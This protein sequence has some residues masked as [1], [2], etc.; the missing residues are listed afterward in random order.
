MGALS[1]FK[2]IEL[3]GL[4]P[5]PMAGMLLADMGAEVIC[6]DRSTEL[7]DLNQKDM[8]RRGKK[9]M[10]IDLKKPEGRELLLQLVAKADALI[11][12]FRPGV[13]ERLGIGPEECLA[14]N[15]KLVYGRMT[16]WG[17]TGPLALRAG[18]DINYISLNGALASVGPAG[19]KPVVPVN[20]VGD[21]GGGAM[22]LVT[23]VLA[24]LLEAQKSG[25]GQVVDA[26]MV[27][28]AA[29]L[30]WMCH[31]YHAVNLWD[32]TKRG[33]NL[34]DGAA[35]F[36]DTYETAD[37]RYVAI[38]AIEPQFFTALVEKA[39]LDPA[40]FNLED[41]MNEAL[42]PELKAELAAVMRTKTRDQ[43]CALLDGSDACFTPVLDAV[44][45]PDHPHNQAR[46]NYLE[47]DGYL[48]PAPAPRFSRTPS[49][50]RH[51][52]HQ[53]GVDNDA[54]LAEFGFSAGDI[55]ALSEAGVIQKYQG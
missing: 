47:I 53:P 17:Q 48:Q 25:K 29:N 19:Q 16:G 35:F 3:T 42:W 22:F 40:R 4:G 36:Y 5:C 9:S 12:G 7:P 33:T 39:G 15:P 28:G 51:G 38:G 24:A 23:G 50:V 32:M 45:A 13:T 18:H 43:W 54:V 30:M 34:L 55:N 52:L 14:V 1:G 27:E 6:I 20:L 49:V 21:F 37:G 8:S 41:Q 26:A 11:E 10:V 2:I 44:E 46:H 31:S